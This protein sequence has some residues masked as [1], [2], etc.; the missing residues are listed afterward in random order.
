MES[1]IPVIKFHYAAHMLYK[2]KIP[3]LPRLICHFMR[4]IY[5]CDI[6]YSAEIHHSVRFAHQALGV[7]IGHDAIIG[8]DTIILQNVTIG[9]RGDR[10]DDYGRDNPVIGRK[11]LIGAGACILG[12]I[13]IGDGA[14]VGANTVVIKDVP[15]GRTVVAATARLLE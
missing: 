9:G 10:R 6:P 3:F 12:P 1:M 15:P 13:R 7:V 5:S 14:S 4:L 2:K 8:A 11:V